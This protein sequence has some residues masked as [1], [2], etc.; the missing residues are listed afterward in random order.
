MMEKKVLIIHMNQL[1]DLFFSL[2]LIYNLNRSGYKIYSIVR[3][4][5]SWIL[6]NTGLCEKVISRPTRL[7]ELFKAATELRK[8]KFDIGILLSFSFSMLL[9]LFFINPRESVGA[10]KGVFRSILL[11]KK[12]KFTSPPAPVNNLSI[13]RALNIHILKTNYVGL[14][15]IP[16]NVISEAKKLLKSKGVKEE[17]FVITIS[18]E[19]SQRRKYKCWDNKNFA[20]LVNAISEEYNVKFIFVGKDQNLAKEILRDIHSGYVIDLVGN[21]TISLLGGI[22]LRSNLIITIDSGV[23]HYASSLERPLIALFGPTDPTL[24]GPQGQNSVVIKKKRMEDITVK[25]VLQEVRKII[26]QEVKK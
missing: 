4:N 19:A 17:D 23:M 1:G 20:T 14:L 9:L 7:K 26:L 22:L 21:T 18:P 25:E 6:E 3:E 5:L 13:L 15:K 10:K 24:V 12:I 11:K 16:E 2:P 8:E